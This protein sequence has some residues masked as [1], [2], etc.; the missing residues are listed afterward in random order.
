MPTAKALLTYEEIAQQIGIP[1]ST[2]KRKISQWNKEATTAQRI[3]PDHKEQKD[4]RPPKF[5]FNPATVTKIKGAIAAL[6]MKGRGRPRT[7]QP[8]ETRS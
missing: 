3:K 1:L 8:K 7:A 6:S 4:D 2:F 5:Y